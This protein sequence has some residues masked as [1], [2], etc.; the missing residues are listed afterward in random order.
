MPPLQDLVVECRVPCR[1]PQQSLNLLLQLPPPTRATRGVDDE[2]VE[3]EAARGEVSLEMRGIPKQIL[4]RSETPT[5]FLCNSFPFEVTPRSIATAE[6][7]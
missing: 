5:D 3:L 7:K 6:A 2:V 1:P 4:A